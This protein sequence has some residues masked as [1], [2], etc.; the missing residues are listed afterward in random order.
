MITLGKYQVCVLDLLTDEKSGRL[1]ATKIWMHVSNA[2]MTKVV[3]THPSLSW[4]LFT[5][6]GAIVGSSHVAIYWLKRKYAD[7]KPVD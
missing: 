6:Y 5:A 7:S 1:S 2:V 3:L 4:D